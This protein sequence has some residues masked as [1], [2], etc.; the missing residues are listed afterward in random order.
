MGSKILTN[1]KRNLDQQQNLPTSL[2]SNGR[3]DS[4]LSS[5]M[6][7]STERFTSSE[8]LMSTDRPFSPAIKICQ[9]SHPPEDFL[10]TERR[11]NNNEELLVLSPTNQTETGLFV[12][13]SQ[14]RVSSSPG[15]FE[16][17]KSLAEDPDFQQFAEILKHET[18]NS[19]RISVSSQASK[20]LKFSEHNWTVEEAKKKASKIQ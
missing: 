15:D 8:G 12:F 3:D 2:Q 13:V 16:G 18:L 20:F 4:P 17:V 5:Q 11:E 10:S 14:Q 9:G 1:L 19:P 7:M 6:L